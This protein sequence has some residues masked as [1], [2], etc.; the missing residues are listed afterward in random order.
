[1]M[2]RMLS[3]LFCL[4]VCFWAALPSQGA[5]RETKALLSGLLNAGAEMVSPDAPPVTPMD[6]VN[7]WK[8][9]Y[10]QEGR[11]YAR[12]LGDIMVERVAEDKKISETLTSVRRLCYAVIAYLTAVTLLILFFFWRIRGILRR[13]EK[14]LPS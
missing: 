6:L 5:S 8:E 3:L 13:M 11:Q 14:K 7:E 2:H 10:K 1:M 12:E 9:E 4:S